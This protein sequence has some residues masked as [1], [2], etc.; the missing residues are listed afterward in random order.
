MRARFLVTFVICGLLLATAGLKAQI[1]TCN[2]RGVVSDQNQAPVAG[3]T[4]EFQAIELGIK[5]VLHTNKKG[6]YFQLGV[7]PGFYNIS[8]SAKGYG[9]YQM[10]ARL[11]MGSDFTNHVGNTNNDNVHNFVLPAAGRN[12][13]DRAAATT[14]ITVVGFTPP[15]S[16]TRQSLEAKRQRELQKENAEIQKRVTKVKGLNEK[17]MMASSAGKAGDWEQ[18]VSFAQEATHMAPDIDLTWAVL[19]DAY[20]GRGQADQAESAYLKA[21][22]LRPNLAGYHNNLA[23]ARSQKNDIEHAVPEFVAAIKM[24]PFNA[25]R[26]YYNMAA[27]FTA[28][29][30]TDDAVKAWEEVIRLDPTKSDAYYWKAFNLNAQAHPGSTTAIS[31]AL[32]QYLE[33]EPDGRYAESAKQMLQEIKP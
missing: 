23:R 6:E 25:S 20:L 13:D 3:A 33:R 29:H 27:A 4:V 18:A 7:K 1:N 5:F 22:E 11:E 8:V 14:N 16:D 30:D 31:E 24:D 2:V 10:S 9:T 21:I 19:G 12:I 26:Y 17:L 28:A 15:T 32:K